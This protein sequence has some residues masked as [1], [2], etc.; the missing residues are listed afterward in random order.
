MRR[1]NKINNGLVLGK[2]ADT[3]IVGS[4]TMADFVQVLKLSLEVDDNTEIRLYNW[5]EYIGI[6]Y[7]VGDVLLFRKNGNI[8]E[9]GK[10]RSI[11]IKQ[12]KILK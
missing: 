12:G 10:I 5:I 7:H 3:D 2:P 8:P 11:V 1:R 4:V 9:F 6:E